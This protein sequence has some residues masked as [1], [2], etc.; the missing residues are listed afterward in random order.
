MD[1]FDVCIV[2]AGVVGLAIAY[3]I[4]RDPQFRNR[5]IVLLERDSS[6]GQHTSS[7]NSEVIHAGIYYA[8]DSLKASL[9]VRG[10]QLLYQ[11]CR[12]LD[13]PCKQ[14]GKYIVGSRRDEEPLQA[15]EARA[16]ANGVS[17]LQWLTRSSLRKNEPALTSE[18]GLFSPS[19]GIIDS[20]AYM[21]SLMH[22]AQNQAM[23]F[24][25]YTR[26]DCVE[27]KRQRFLVECTITASSRPEQYTFQCNLLINSA[28][29][30]AQTLAQNIADFDQAS[31]PELHMCKGCYFNF[32]GKNPFQRLIYPLPEANETG[33]GIHAIL[34][35]SSQLRFGPDTEYVDSIDYDI[36]PCRSSLF[37]AAVA[38]YF[39]AV[40]AELLVPAYAGIR[41]KIAAAGEAPGDFVILDGA[42][43]GMPG[44]IQLFGME[45]PALTASLA[46]GELV[47]D[48]FSGY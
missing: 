17:D 35:L 30:H 27:F 46:I 34:D 36:D 31:I 3:Q 5:S 45:S 15:I 33:L 47:R 28:G 43:H 26:I 8:R 13:V 7:R 48:K 42:E 14:L 24:A 10:K 16:E 39:P 2:G 32:T 38:K 22:L 1:Q 4:S 18:T 41:P 19:T 25:P 9:C 29:L 20:H 12:Q 6:F 11:H 44:L 40:T 37:A 21:Q 23:H